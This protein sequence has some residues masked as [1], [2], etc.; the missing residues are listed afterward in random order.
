MIM[1]KAGRYVVRALAA[2]GFLYVLVSA[3]AIDRWWIRF[4]AGP[5]ND[6][7]GD[8]LVVLG[9][10]SVNDVIGAGSYWRSVYAVRVWREGGFR[11]VIVC[12]GPGGG[13][14]SIS[15]R[16]RDYMMSQGVPSAAIRVE[17][18][19]HSTRENALFSKALIES[20]A[21]R[22]VLLTSDYHMFRAYRVFRKAGIEVE[23]RPIPDAAKQIDSWQTRWS[24][25]VN[26]CAETAKIGYYFARGWI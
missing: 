26:L 8:V 11:E 16:M 24:V 20:A 4:L 1:R 21:G 22:K 13:P 7:K 25:F 18:E 9:A 5:W 12:G 19:S 2:I 15:E 17:T 10:D 23:P 3:T 6:P 14:L